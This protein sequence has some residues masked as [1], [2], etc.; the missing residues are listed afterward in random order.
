MERKPQKSS[1]KQFTF[2]Y[3]N[4]VCKQDYFIKSPP[5]QLFFSA[6]SWKKRFFILSK[7]GEKDFSLSY[8]KDHHHRG[9]IEIDRNSSVEVG[10]RSH[11]KMQSVQK[12]FKCHPNE[13]MSIKT[14]NREYF[15]IGCDREKIRDWVSFLSSLCRDMRAAHQNTEQEKLSSGDKRPSSDPL[16]GTFRAPE[17]VSATIPRHSLPD[18]R[19]VKERSPGLR[20]A[21]LSHDFSSEIY[22]DS[23]EDS[24]YI[25]PRSILL[26][27]DIIAPNDSDELTDPIGPHSPDKVSKTAECHYLS[28]KSCL[29]KELSLESVDGKEEFQ[30]LAEIQN[31]ELHQRE[32][33]SGTHFYLPPANSEAQTTNDSKQSASLT[34]VQLSILINNIPDESKVQKLNVF[35]SPPDIKNYL[36]LK[37][38]AGRICVAQWDAPPRL[39]CLFFHGDHLL[40]VNDLKPQSL[41]EVSLFLSRS[42]PREK[43]KLTIGR[44]P[45]SEKFHTIACTCSL[46]DK[47]VQPSQLV[48]SVL[49]GTLKRTPAIRKG[50]QGRSGE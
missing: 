38:A 19:L 1:G 18:M 12:M 23:E 47:G 35:L 5:P 31:G 2:Y 20:E 44:I 39:G 32:Q 14:T 7:S 6:T 13:V 48:T 8:Y 43:V 27:L 42:I 37:E 29:L 22:Q 26:E 41:E 11:E 28:M 10:I 17:I 45:N 21:R 46:Q 30:P 16:L 4:E 3:E 49:P 34:V 25:S 33:A 15:L 36:V 50:Q 24:H 40:A 9:S